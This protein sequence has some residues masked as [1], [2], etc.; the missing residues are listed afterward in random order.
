MKDTYLLTTSPHIHNAESTPRVMY[1]VV[2]ALIPAVLVSIYYFGL[3]ALVVYLVSIVSCLAFEAAAQKV[4]GRPITIADGRLM[5]TGSRLS[6]WA[7][8]STGGWDI[9]RSTRSSWRGYCCLCRFPC[10]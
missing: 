9:I 10:R 2:I 6:S 7:S 5:I 4:M 3:S 1:S 8:R